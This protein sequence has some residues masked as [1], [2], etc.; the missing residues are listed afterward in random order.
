MISDGS[1]ISTGRDFDVILALWG[2]I[3]ARD[4]WLIRPTTRL[5]RMPT[6]AIYGSNLASMLFHLPTRH[7]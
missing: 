5:T 6:A 4:L 1:S 2:C 3:I 7:G